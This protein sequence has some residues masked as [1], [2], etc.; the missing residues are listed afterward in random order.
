MF[1]RTKALLHFLKVVSG[2][3]LLTPVVTATRIN[4]HRKTYTRQS[5]MRAR[6]LL[7]IV[8]TL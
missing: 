2:I 3:V 4:E 8:Y 1:D 5:R 6:A 7:I